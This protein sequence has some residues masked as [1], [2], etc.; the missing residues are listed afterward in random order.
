MLT[1]SCL[2]YPQ[3]ENTN[4]RTATEIRF[5]DNQGGWNSSYSVNAL[6]YVLIK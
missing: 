4:G 2:Q 3:N 1:T 6:K 5:I